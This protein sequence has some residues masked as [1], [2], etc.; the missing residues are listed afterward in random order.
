MSQSIRH[1]QL[2]EIQTNIQAALEVRKKK[3]KTP[4]TKRVVDIIANVPTLW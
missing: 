2:L 1:P 4:K 3:E